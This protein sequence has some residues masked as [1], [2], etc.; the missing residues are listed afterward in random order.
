MLHVAAL[1]LGIW[2]L[3]TARMPAW[4]SGRRTTAPQASGGWQPMRGPVRAGIAGAAWIAWPCG[5]SQSALLL[6]ALNDGAAGGAAS[7]AAFAIASSPGL[8]LLP[9]VLQRARGADKGGIGWPIRI[10]GAALA[11]A[12]AWALGHGLWQ[13]VA[14][15]CFA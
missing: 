5:L 7:M 11:V 4:A 3:A 14:E 6:A 10:A 1:A 9:L 13:R 8:A 2:M 15:W 12:S